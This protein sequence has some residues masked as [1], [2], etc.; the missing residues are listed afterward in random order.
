MARTPLSRPTDGELAILRILWDRGPSTVREI[1]AFESPATSAMLRVVHC[2]ACAGGGPSRVRVINSTIRSSVA[3]R[4]APGR[5]SSVNPPRRRTRNR[6]R[7]LQTQ[8][9]D[10]CSRVA[11]ARLVRPSAH[12]R[13]RRDR[14]ASRCAVFGR[15]THWSN[16]RRSSSVSSNGLW[17]RC[18]RMSRRVPGPMTKYKTFSETRH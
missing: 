2:V 14:S 6:S 1:V 13:T 16:I 10:T 5:G 8:L 17:W 7:H 9:L 11:T 15:R 18:R 12:A 4:G 3:L